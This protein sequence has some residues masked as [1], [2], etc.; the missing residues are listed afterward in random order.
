MLLVNESN[1]QVHSI[2]VKAQ[3][4]ICQ[5]NTTPFLT[6][7]LKSEEQKWWT[8][9][10]RETG[11]NRAKFA[12]WSSQ[13]RQCDAIDL[14]SGRFVVVTAIWNQFGKWQFCFSFG[15]G[16]A[17]HL[18]RDFG[19]ICETEFPSRQVAEYLLRQSMGQ[20]SEPQDSYRRKELLLNTKQVY[21][22]WLSDVIICF[23]NSIIIA[24]HKRANGPAEPRSDTTVQYATTTDSGSGHATPSDAFFADIARFWIACHRR[25]TDRHSGIWF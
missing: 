15:S 13:S 4:S 9:T 2:Y 14:A 1:R 7:I 25:R 24:D 12:S 6:F 23:T 3:Y 19:Y 22:Q 20:H 17:I 18:A 16:E 21:F 8:I 10:A 11:E 5:R